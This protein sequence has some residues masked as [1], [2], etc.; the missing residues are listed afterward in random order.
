MNVKNNLVMNNSEIYSKTLK[1]Y[2]DGVGTEVIDKL[3]LHNLKRAEVPNHAITFGVIPNNGLNVIGESYI[4]K[5]VDPEKQDT[6]QILS[7][8]EKGIIKHKD[9]FSGKSIPI[10]ISNPEWT[11]FVAEFKKKFGKVEE[12]LDKDHY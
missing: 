10:I 9:Y 7:E 5:P 8:L 2:Y 11:D 1:I 6:A 4:T 3:N 12:Y